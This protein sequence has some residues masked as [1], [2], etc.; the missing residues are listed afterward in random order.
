M[1][2]F[3]KVG[4]A[5]P[6]VAILLALAPVATR[7]QPRPP[8]DATVAGEVTSVNPLKVKL[9]NGQEQLLQ[10]SPTVVVVREG[11]EVKLGDLEKGDKVVF[12]TNPDNSVQR[13]DVTETATDPTP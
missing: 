7:A 6:V 10:T 5:L 4:L 1:S 13:M 9:A 2:R 11:K 3:A 12:S 8:G